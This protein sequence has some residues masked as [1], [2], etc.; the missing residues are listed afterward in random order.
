M[1]TLEIIQKDI[2]IRVREVPPVKTQEITRMVRT[3]NLPSYIYARELLKN[4]FVSGNIKAE[5]L[6]QVP[7]EDCM[8]MFA[9]MVSEGFV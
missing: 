4:G 8:A 1:P 7:Q 5:D 6:D 9:K 3:D 2:R